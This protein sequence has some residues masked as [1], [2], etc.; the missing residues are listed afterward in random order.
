MT[1]HVDLHAIVLG[2][3]SV[4]KGHEIAHNL[5]NKL[6]QEMPEL[7]DILIHIEPEGIEHSQFPS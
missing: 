6:L 1:F 7:A 4:T 2:E 5:K 3:L